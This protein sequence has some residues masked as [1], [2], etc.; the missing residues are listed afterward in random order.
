MRIFKR[1]EETVARG[2]EIWVLLSLFTRVRFFMSVAMLLHLIT[3]LFAV[4]YELFTHLKYSCTLAL[5]ESTL[6]WEESSVCSSG[7]SRPI[8]LGG[9]C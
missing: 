1:R 6:F 2:E 7:G 8:L 5:V 9:P 3:G 4:H